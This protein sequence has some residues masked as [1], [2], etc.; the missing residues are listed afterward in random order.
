M[1]K[2]DVV[3]N[4]NETPACIARLAVVLQE[5]GD[6]LVDCRANGIEPADAFTRVGVNIPTYAKPMLNMMFRGNETAPVG[7]VPD[8]A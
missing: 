2:A 4:D 6:A 5:F 1:R 8:A 7:A 3:S